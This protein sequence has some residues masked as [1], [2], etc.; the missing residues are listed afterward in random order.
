[1]NADGTGRTEILEIG[2][3]YQL[4]GSLAAGNGLIFVAAVN[5]ADAVVAQPVVLQIAPRAGRRRNC[6]LAA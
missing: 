4:N 1:M 3:E 2:E 6:N 5:V